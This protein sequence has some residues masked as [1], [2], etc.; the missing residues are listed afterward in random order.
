MRGLWR[1]AVGLGF[2]LLYNELAWTY[3]LVSWVVSLGRWRD[4]QRS[5]RSYLPE[6]G[7]VLE[8]GFGPGHLLVELAGNGYQPVGLD[9][10]P[11][12]LR[13][14]RRNL[15]R[16]EVSVP[17]CR[18]RAQAL[19][20]APQSFDAVVVTFPTPY[21]YDP[22]WID[23]LAR[24][25][26]DKGRL[27]V[28]EMARFTQ[29]SPHVRIIEGLYRATG[30]RGPAPHLAGLLAAAGLVAWYE[31]V[32]VRGTQVSLVLADKPAANAQNE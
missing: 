26:R 6:N 32:E 10:S 7:R 5:T 23:G 12:M 14:A 13:L 4:W 22:V 11:A 3:D 25:L 19:P 30:Q 16:R 2:R 27:V 20:F 8:V 1:R 18:G 29:R 17:L 15:R 9:L 24:V 21:V 28:V 31:Q